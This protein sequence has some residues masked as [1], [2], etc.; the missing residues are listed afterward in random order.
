MT[1]KSYERARMVAERMRAERERQGLSRG[2]VAARL[3]MSEDLYSRIEE[4]DILEAGFW[5]EVPNV[6]W[7]LGIP[8]EALTEGSGI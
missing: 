7:A 3:L 6:A 2:R 5:H 8:V 1:T 4:A